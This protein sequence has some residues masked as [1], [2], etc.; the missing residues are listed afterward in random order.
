MKLLL[1]K[2]SYAIEIGAYLAYTGH[3]KVTNDKE[4]RRIAREELRHMVMI[5]RILASYNTTP[6]K[7]F[8][9]KFLAVGNTI[10]Y[11]CYILPKWFLNWG[12]GLL[13][14]LNVVN[15]NHMAK[16]FP[17]FEKEFKEMQRN[18]EEH[19]QYFKSIS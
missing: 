9:L 10:K 3:Y 5:K 12:A 17:E 14:I 11:S 15:Y 18:E 7:L 8:N 6:N 1:L 2:L 4:I 16:M 19:E 13:E